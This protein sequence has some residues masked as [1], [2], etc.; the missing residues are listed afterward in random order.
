MITWKVTDI[1]KIVCNLSGLLV[2]DVVVRHE[3]KGNTQISSRVDMM[4]ACNV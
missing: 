2:D 4:N 3:K 1:T